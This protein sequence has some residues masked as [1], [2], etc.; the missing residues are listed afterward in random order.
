MNGIWV[1]ALLG[2]MHLGLKTG[3]LCPKD[4]IYYE[5]VGGERTEWLASQFDGWGVALSSGWSLG[6]VGALG[7]WFGCT[8]VGV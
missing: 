3:H 8:E 6:V 1:R 4:R 5:G 7:I 2:L